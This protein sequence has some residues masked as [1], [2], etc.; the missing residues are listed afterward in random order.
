MTLFPE[1]RATAIGLANLGGSFGATYLGNLSRAY[2][3]PENIDPSIQVMEGDRISKYFDSRVTEKF[4]E[5]WSVLGAVTLAAGFLCVPWMK[6]SPG[7]FSMLAYL[8]E[9]FL[10]TPTM[11][12]GSVSPE[13]RLSVSERQEI[14]E[15]LQTSRNFQMADA[16]TPVNRTVQNSVYNSP[17]RSRVSYDEISL[18]SDPGI[19]LSQK[20]VSRGSFGTSFDLDDL[21][22]QDQT[23]QGLE[24]L[25]DA[26][27]ES[28]FSEVIRTFKFISI[29]IAWPVIFAFPLLSC[30]NL[31]VWGLVNFD[32][33]TLTSFAIVFSIVP[34][35][36][37]LVCGLIIDR[38]SLTLM[39]RFWATIYVVI[40][41]LFYFFED[42]LWVF[43][44]SF[45]MYFFGFAFYVT[46]W[47]VT[48]VYIYG[49]QL[50]AKLQVLLGPIPLLM[51]LTVQFMDSCILVNFGKGVYTV[52]AVGI[53]IVFIVVTEKCNWG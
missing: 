24:W 34:A 52:L 4:S 25:T 31:K 9:K 7:M 47:P 43:V 8:K 29:L 44:L 27:L 41:V 20:M 14:T 17:P 33:R 39:I 12:D 51:A 49:V 21:E 19:E 38:F 30:I 50:G 26:E 23:Q 40:T 5:F 42:N 10:V 37:R 3:N 2:M 22:N 13:S 53:N 16:M 32:D 11:P 48:V 36:G 35:M 28:K 45:S 6:A 46:S 1:H 15:K 18:F